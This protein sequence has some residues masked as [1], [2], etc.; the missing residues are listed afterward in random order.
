MSDQRPTSPS[1]SEIGH[2]FLSSV[3]QRA[4]EGAPLPRRQPP[5]GNR[6][7]VMMTIPLRAEERAKPAE[8]ETLHF[9]PITALLSAHL[10]GTQR[11]RVW[12][13]ARH[14]ASRGQRIGLI[15]LDAGEFRVTSFEKQPA[16]QE[17][18]NVIDH[19]PTE[20]NFDARAAA[21]ALAEMS[22]DV[23]RW[24]V[25]L[26]GARGWEAKCLL[27]DIGHWALLGTCDHEGVVSCYRTIKGL[28]PGGEDWPRPRLTLALLD[29]VDEAES[30]AVHRKL[31]NVCEQFLG[32]PLQAEAA[33]LVVGDVVERPVMCCRLPTP[34]TT[35]KTVPPHWQVVADFLAKAKGK[36]EPKP[37]VVGKTMIDT[38]P[39]P[40]VVVSE[41]PKPETPPM[42]WTGEEKSDVAEVIEL[43]G[44]TTAAILSSVLRNESSGLIECP[45]SAPACPEAKLAVTRERRLVL[46]A[47]GG[48]GLADLRAIG[49]AYQWLC[50]NRPLIAMALPQ[51]AIDASAPPQLRLFVE[52]VDLNAAALQPML[53]QGTVEVLAY[54]RLRWGGRNGLLLEAA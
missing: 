48:Q 39:V 31:S 22:W 37:K 6:E 10:G 23:D 1:L 11:E 25:L 54:R 49:K 8:V 41:T 12:S 27:R 50:E 2:L 9:P 34:A 51:V 45:I 5:A 33:V 13:Y 28:N 20:E 44:T 21:D 46:L 14:L 52:H 19:S 30:D 38:I 47:V 43:S 42:R 26:P 36:S 18:D 24:L 15:E 53:A 32:V 40:P 4:T 3:R 7:P 17:V 29:S 16:E 35:Q